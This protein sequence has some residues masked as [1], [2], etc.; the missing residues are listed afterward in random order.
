[1]TS[2]VGLIV[3]PIAGMGGRVGLKGT[4][5]PEILRRA[6]EL[7]AK[8]WA[9][10]RAYE[11]MK[12]LR[13]ILDDSIEVYAYPDRM[14]ENS[15][16]RAGFSPKVIGDLEGREETTAEDTVRAAKEMKD[17]GVNLILFTGGDGTARDIYRAIDG[18]QVVLGI[19]AGVK[20]YSS[21]FAASPRAAG[22]LAAR[23]LRGQVTEVIEAEVLDI[24]EEAFREGRLSI[25]LYGYL[26]IPY[27]SLYIPGGKIPSSHSEKY[28]KEAAAAEFIDNMEE[29]CIYIIGPGTTTK[30]IMRK[31]GLD[32]TLLGVDAIQG[33]KLIGKDLNERQILDLISGKRAKVVVSPI[34][35]QG[36][37]FG[38]GNQQ[39]SP[40]VL[41]MIG[42][43]NIVVIATPGKIESLRGRPMLIDT[44]DEKLDRELSGYYRVILGYREYIMYKVIPGYRESF[45]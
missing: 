4:D 17:L 30:E 8:P 34:G 33:R 27:D 6:I 12:T 39:I 18:E 28:A 43:E 7:G 45:S 9:E 40:R 15:A 29:D 10:D 38:R 21:V 24:D 14:G 22:E 37:I 35:G 44:G 19:P 1:M 36:Y 13:S 41:R 11:A 2:K 5:G 42:K 16:K 32:Y 3:N 26:K 20:V 31:L 25:R 23:F